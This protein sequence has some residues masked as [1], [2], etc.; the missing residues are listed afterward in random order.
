MMQKAIRASVT[1][2][3][4]DEASDSLRFLAEGE[5]SACRLRRLT[6]RIGNERIAQVDQQTRAYHSMALP[7]QQQ[8][9]IG[10]APDVAC[11]ESDGGRIQIRDRYAANAQGEFRDGQ[12]RA[13]YWR[14]TK[15]VVLLKMTSQTYA[16]DPCP[17]IPEVFVS[18]PRMQ[19]LSREIKGFLAQTS[20]NETTAPVASP[21]I[22]VPQDTLLSANELHASTRPEIVLRT[23]LASTRNI[24][25]FGKQIANRGCRSPALT[26]NRRSSN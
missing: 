18:A 15:A 8:C 22:D 14:E 11:V 19:R 21:I 24:Q 9:P 13:S 20:D 12:P 5:V 23:V 7:A 1:S 25:E 2:S 4:F 26:S 17:T 6:E 16:E 10:M 3:G